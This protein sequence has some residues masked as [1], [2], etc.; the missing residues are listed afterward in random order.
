M[1]C[2]LLGTHKGPL[3]L[4]LVRQMKGGETRPRLPEPV[5]VQIRHNGF[6][7]EDATRLQL[8]TDGTRDVDTS[9]A[10]YG[11][12]G[13][14]DRLAFVTVLLRG[15]RF[16][17][18]PVP[19]VDEGLIVLPVP[20]PDSN[21]QEHPSH[22]R[23]ESLRRNVQESSQV[24][25]HLFERINNLTGR[26]ETLAEALKEVR[27]TLERSREDYLKFSEEQD[28]LNK[29]IAKMKPEDQPPNYRVVLTAILSRLKDLEKG[30]SE[31]IGH[32]KVLE[33]IEKEENDPKRKEWLIKQERARAL[34][35]ESELGKAIEIYEKAPVEFMTPNLKK[36]I[37]KLKE[38]LEDARQG[39]R[40]REEVHLHRLADLEHERDGI[41]Y[42]G[43]PGSRERV[44]ES[45]RP[46]RDDPDAQGDRSARSANGEGAFRPEAGR[47]H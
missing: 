45:H 42:Q 30:Q 33:K 20:D 8:S 40:G 29:A 15:N 38:A 14:F 27:I 6:V 24:Q 17:R 23:L 47:E 31:L 28:E 36:H 5:T 41:A 18:M 1:R 26:P 46:G 7:A 2:V 16:V 13:I 4:R 43:S 3:R 34:E 39:T 35:N 32:L 19:L 12:K 25:K 44:Q 22:F 21:A 11:E 9:N 37:E 10:R